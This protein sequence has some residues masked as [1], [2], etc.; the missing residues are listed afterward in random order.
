MDW[1]P[2]QDVRRELQTALLAWGSANFRDFPWREE[3]STPYHVLVAELLLKRTT[4]TAAARVFPQFIERY[5]T[6]EKFVTARQDELVELFRPVG[7]SQQRAR[8]VGDLIEALSNQWCR[9]IPRELQQLKTLP[10]LG[11]YAARAVLSLGFGIPA[12]VVDG[13]VRRILGRVFRDGMRQGGDESQF[14]RVADWLLPRR[15]HRE[16]NLALLDLGALVCRPRLPRCPS[17]PLS[18]V[19][20]FSRRPIELEHSSKLRNVRQA[21]RVSMVQLSVRS[22]VSKTT[23]MNAEAGLTS[24]RPLTLKRLAATLGVPVREIT[25]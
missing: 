8:T 23:I 13:N 16:F 17:C 2:S 14:Q 19:C 4:A 1:L 9:Q 15:H 12:A 10:G 25:G 22:G 18:D 21:K 24:P 11:D 3:S 7:L 6:I 20:D 5:L